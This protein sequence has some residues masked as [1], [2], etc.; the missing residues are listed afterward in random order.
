MGL[1]D[2]LTDLREQAQ[3][4]VAEHKD[5]IQNAMDSAGTAVDQKTHGKYTDKIMKFGQKASDAVE[6]FSDQES[7]E[8]DAAGHPDSPAAKAPPAP[9]PGSGT[10]SP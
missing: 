3:G 2:K 10:S 7:G 9:T 5:Q 8:R 1:R 4:A 6:K